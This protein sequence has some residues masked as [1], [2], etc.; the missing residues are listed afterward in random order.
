[1]KVEY[2]D[3]DTVRVWTSETGGRALAELV[4][5]LYRG[6]DVEVLERKASATKVRLGLTREGWVRAP[7]RTAQLDILHSPSSM[8]AKG[9]PA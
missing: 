7:L 9:T 3:H 8:W 6:D 5:V 4:A 1:M 2:V